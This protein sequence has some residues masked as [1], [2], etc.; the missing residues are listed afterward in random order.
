MATAKKKTYTRSRSRSAIARIRMYRHGLGDCFLVALPKKGGGD[1]YLMI[2]CGV[3]LGTEKPEPLM[4]KVVDDIIKTTRGRVDVLA[5][6]HEHWDHVSG[7]V[8]AGGRFA[9]AKDKAKAGK[10][11]IGQ[12]W[13]AWTEDSQNKL[14]ARLKKEHAAKKAR[15]KTAAQRLHGLTGMESTAEGIDS[16]LSFFGAIGGRGPTTSDAFQALHDFTEQK[17]LICHPEKPPITLDQVP[18]YRI[19]VLGPPEDEASIKKTGSSTELYQDHLAMAAQEE[20]WQNALD[21]DSS[22][23]ELRPFDR[24]HA[25]PIDALAQPTYASQSDSN[26]TAYFF[27]RYYFGKDPCSISPDQSW[28]RID[29][30]WLGASVEF[31]LQLDSATNNTSLVLALEHKPTGKVLLFA[32]D[33]QVGNWLSWLKREWNV[34]GRKVTGPDL[35]KRTVFYK[36][37]HHGSHNATLKANGLEQMTSDDLVAFIPVNHEMAKKKHWGNMPL[38]ALCAALKQQTRGR[39][40]RIDEEFDPAACDPQVRPAFKSALTATD[41]YYELEVR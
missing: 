32:A 39:T 15:L 36:V 12:L 31:A 38:K 2:D 23:D 14:A 11:R 7:F 28:R 20:A 40:V 16:V 27:E 22:D 33:A 29:G 4:A 17:A 37:G 13:L 34:D 19:Y 30:D 35:L 25:I 8:Q 41:L 10:L 5:A 3:V 24:L 6:T 26:P 1:F 9:K 21:P 18:D